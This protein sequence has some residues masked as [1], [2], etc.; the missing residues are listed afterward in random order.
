M[1]GQRGFHTPAP[2]WSISTKMKGC[3]Q[4]PLSFAVVFAGLAFGMLAQA[5]RGVELLILVGVL[6]RVAAE[7]QADRGS[8]HVKVCAQAVDQIA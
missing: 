6:V 1:T 3:W 4:A 2:P 7:G 5:R 8:R